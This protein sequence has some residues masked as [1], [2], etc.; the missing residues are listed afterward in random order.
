MLQCH[1][2]ADPIV[3]IGFGQLTARALQSVL[4]N[5]ELKTYP[6]MGHSSND[7]VGG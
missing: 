3:N 1:G 4:K 2:N 6:N 5:H 7:R